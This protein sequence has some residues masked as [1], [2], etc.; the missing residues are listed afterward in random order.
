MDMVEQTRL[1]QLLSA[2]SSARDEQQR[3]ATFDNVA[4]VWVTE[5]GFTA[6]GDE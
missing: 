3:P 2:C 4:R 1:Q 6:S 5:V